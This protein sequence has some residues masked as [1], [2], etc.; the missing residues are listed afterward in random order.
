MLRSDLHAEQSG[1]VLAE[2]I[3][4]ADEE[5]WLVNPTHETM[6][7]FV[8][9]VRA[10]GPPSPPAEPVRVLAA[11]EPLKR[12]NQDFVLASHAADLVG[13]GPLSVRLMEATPRYSLLVTEQSVV[14]LVEC[15][16]RVAG[17]TSTRDRFVEE[18]REES[19]RRWRRG[20][21]FS[22][23]TPPL[24]EIRGTLAAELDEQTAREFD[25]MLESLDAGAG[26]L[27]EVALALLV[28]ARNEQLL[29]DISRWGEEIQL[30]SK[31]TFSRSKNTL[32]TAGLIETEKVP[33]EIGRP[34]LRLFLQEE[35]RGLDTETLLARAQSAVESA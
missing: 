29:Y 22:L 21:G 9:T 14:S 20:E 32:E 34:R 2:G 15:E 27:D 31:A 5:L 8:H 1:D 6:A 25:R 16:R 12:L 11:E 19:R 24:S 33:I 3:E 7:E 26:P 30:A 4:A 35:Y 17:L 10:S 13:E 18:A 28:A 23:R